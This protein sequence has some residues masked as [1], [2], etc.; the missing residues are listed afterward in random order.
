ML[1]N[2]SKRDLDLADS[3]MLDWPHASR[4]VI[5]GMSSQS[6][7]GRWSTWNEENVGRMEYIIRHDLTYD[8][9]RFGLSRLTNVGIPCVEEFRWALRIVSLIPAVHAFRAMVMSE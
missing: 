6:R 3:L 8:G 2:S 1:W 4:R 7:A 9:Y 5:L